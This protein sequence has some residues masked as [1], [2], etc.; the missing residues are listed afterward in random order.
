MVQATT[1][2]LMMCMANTIGDQQQGVA[3][4]DCDALRRNFEVFSPGFL[5]IVV[6]ADFS[7]K[8]NVL[9]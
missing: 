6:D 5:S 4:L 7:P 9:L 3:V 2:E 1:P 8:R